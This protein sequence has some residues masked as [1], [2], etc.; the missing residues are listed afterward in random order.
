MSESDG[1]TAKSALSHKDDENVTVRRKVR[2]SNT[3]SGN[4]VLKVQPF[5]PEEPEMWFALLEGQFEA[6]NITSDI[7]K[8]TSVINNLDLTHS[9]AVKDIILQPPAENKY[10]KIKAELVKRLSASKEKKVRQLLVH[11][12][13]GD[14]KPSQFLRHLQD[15]AGPSVP[16]D[17]IQSIWSS[18]LPQSLQT[19]LASQASLSLEQLADLADRIQEIAAP[20]V[21]AV[22]STSTT[23]QQMCEITELKKMVERLT[24][25]LE[26]HTRSAQCSSI[27]SRSRR[28]SSS[29]QRSRSSSSYQVGKPREQSL[30]TTGDCCAAS[31]RLFVTD[32]ITRLQFL[33]DTGSDLCVYPSSALHQRR[34]KTDF[35]LSAANG[36][37]I[38]TF[39][40]VE[41]SLDLGLRRSFPWRFIV[42]SVTK[43]IIGV[44]FLSNY[45]LVVDCRN[46]R[47]LDSTT[48]LSTNACLANT[49]DVHSVKVSLGDTRYHAILAKYPEIT[50]PSGTLRTPKHSTIHYIRTTP[51]PSIS[52]T[53]RRL[54]PD[55]LKI[56]KQEFQ[57][58]LNNGTARPSDSP[59]ASPLHLA[60]KKDN[61]WRPCGDYRLLNARTIPDRYPIRHIH[62]FAHSIAGCKVFSTIDLVKAYNQIPIFEDDI[63]K[64]AI[65]TP[66]GLYEFP[67]MT[68][69]LRNAGQTFQR[70]VDE[71][72]RGLDFCYAYLDDFLIFSR[73]PEDHETH[74]E[75]LFSRMKEYGI[76][77]N[78]SKCIFGASQVNFL[79]YSISEAGTKPLESKVQAIR[80][81]PAPTNV[82]Q[83]RRFLGMVNFYRRFL[84]NS[85]QIQAPLNSLLA[86][87]VKA[88]HPVNLTGNT[89][90]SFEQCKESLSNAALLAHPDSDAKL[91]LVTDASDLAL[92]AV[93]QQWKED[94]WQPLAF[95]SRKLSPSQRKYSPYDRE[96]L[97]IYESIKY[98]RHML[99]AR[100][101]VVYTD[102]KPISYA[103]H[104][105][106]ANCSPRQFR[107]LDYISQ[108]TTD[109]RHISGKSNV[110]ADTLSRVDELS[111]SIDY[112]Q[113]ASSQAVDEEL[114]QLLSGE[115]SLRIKK[116]SLP[117][118]NVAIYCDVSTPSPRPFVTKPLRKQLFDSLHN[119]SHP[120]ANATARLVAERFV[121]PGMRKDCREWSRK[122]LACQRAK[123][124]R[125]VSSPLGTFNLPRARF[126]FIHV[127]I[128][129]PLPPSQGFRYCTTIV[130]RFTRWPEVI[131][132][133]D[134]T[135][136]TVGKAVL[137]WISMFGCPSDI[138]TDRG[139]Q[140]ESTLFQYLGK[141]IGF[142]HRRTTACNGLVERFHRQL[143]A[144]IMCHADC[145]WV[146]TLPL[147]LL[148]IRSA[149][150]EDLQS[151][152][153][154]LVFGEPLRLPGEFFHA[155]IP[156]SSDISDFSTR[157]RNSIRKLN[158]TPAA[159]HTKEKIFIFR[160]LN[161]SSH[162]FLRDDTVR[163]SL[164][165]PYSGP[166]EVLDRGDKIFKILVKGKPTTVS[167]DRLKPAYVLSDSSPAPTLEPHINPN[168]DP[169][170]SP[171]VPT[172]STLPHTTQSN[173]KKTRT[174][175]VVRFPD[176]YRP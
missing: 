69:G 52:C 51:G 26:E 73:T 36:S 3:P 149:F 137:S 107:H 101:F 159:R 44:D 18:R 83:L 115:S 152:S 64:T 19:V 157:L 104:E 23:P 5:C 25:K 167:V 176:Y 9:K 175:R 7:K 29:R 65:T 77:V 106:K 20:S 94:Q 43:P 100:H 16:E 127:D 173:V 170:P 61:G 2:V 66:F 46:Q 50:R 21:A 84:P 112:D 14:R 131:P 103:F 121:W 171:T 11:E 164:Q 155:T 4:E 150:K 58:M 12:H 142:R 89:L 86:G 123:V 135:A 148:G 125:H 62:D 67:Y 78:T 129:G 120:G 108:F 22:A 166:H 144:A 133:A 53:P 110:V 85:A 126:A 139:R 35:Q 70:F 30:M 99:E 128:V 95:F 34:T 24:L 169:I 8:Y 154:E 93:L 31:G 163:G 15:L 40:F 17:F 27:R 113:L 79:G 54:A 146:D 13:L 109:I 28:R 45:N 82:R 122:C 47:L 38:E 97:A 151:S 33:V 105:R 41:L 102:H 74:L 130:D 1:D 138:V 111:M 124:S 160:D 134:M 49:I 81:F 55:K 39:G 91:A 114:A 32:R 174:G 156:G 90:A 145:N 96:L 72:T 117:N 92:G 172:S 132:M 98:F 75:L 56:A 143:K 161:T 136:E 42:A 63:Q 116:L 10:N 168:T 141:M 60:P 119:L 140:F 37:V 118:S 162:V 57:L 88:S 76:L 80:E 48:T 87:S 6:F 153:A 158:P 147:V 165:P 71:M 59:W 68:F